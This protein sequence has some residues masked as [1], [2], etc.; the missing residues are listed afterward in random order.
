MAERNLKTL[1]AWLAGI[2]LIAGAVTLAATRRAPGSASERD[3]IPGAEN[4]RERQPKAAPNEWVPAIVPTNQ[5][6]VRGFVGDLVAGGFKAGDEQ[7]PFLIGDYVHLEADA[8]NAI[9]YRWTANG[10]VLKEKGAEWSKRADR[11]Y[12]VK[13]AGELHFT[14]EVRGDDPSGVSA[15]KEAVLQTKAVHILDFDKALVQ[16]EDRALTGDDFRVEA[17]LAEALSADLDFYE[18]RYSV[19]DVP[20]KHPD[21]GKEW[22]TERDFTYRFP[23]P[24]QYSF[25]VEV[26]RAGQPQAEETRTLLETITVADAVALTFDAYP[27][28]SAPLGATI[29]LDVF[30]QSLFGKAEVRFGYKKVVEPNF[31]WIPEDDGASWGAGERNWLPT[32]P[33]NY[34]LRTEVRDTGKQQADDFRELLYTITEGNF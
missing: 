25:K 10:E 5:P 30:P 26:R 21:D 15:P 27:E 6:M 18:L 11:E 17:N 28:K 2:A 14:V 1:W 3:S 4:L 23:S 22:T 7:I 8:V 13:S 12:E 20:M 16:E 34:I 19:N 29:S 24:G 32:E 31:S 9:E 33:G